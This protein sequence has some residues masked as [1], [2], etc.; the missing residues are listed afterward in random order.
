[1]MAACTLISNHCHS[2]DVFRLL[3]LPVTESIALTSITE[4]AMNTVN[5]FSLQA[6]RFLSPL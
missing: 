5:T 3:L 6:T 4:P 2:V 1:M